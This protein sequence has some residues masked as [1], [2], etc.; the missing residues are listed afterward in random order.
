[1]NPTTLDPKTVAA[2]LCKPGALVLASRALAKSLREEVDA[3]K[4]ELLATGDYTDQYKGGRVTE[5]SKDWHIS[6]D[7]SASYY[8]SLAQLIA[9]AG[10]EVPEGY[11]PALMAESAQRDAEHALIEASRPFFGVTGSQLLCGA[12]KGDGLETHR[13]FID[14]LLQLVVVAGATGLLS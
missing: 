11:C 8:E 4:R 6:D 7:E 14:H 1:M 2:A 3:I 5:P 9:A 13:K 10:H 12:G